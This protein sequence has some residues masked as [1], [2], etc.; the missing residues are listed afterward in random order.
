MP[1]FL[2]PHG[3]YNPWNSPGQNTGVG[4][5]SLLQGSSQPR[6]QTQVSRIAGRFFTS[7]A[8]REALCLFG[9][10]KYLLFSR[11]SLYIFKVFFNVDCFLK[12]F[13]NLLQYCFCCMFWFFWPWGMWDLSYLLGFKPAPPSLEG[14]VSTTGPPEKSQRHS[15]YFTCLSS[16]ER[17][18]S[19]GILI[20][21]IFRWNYCS[22]HF[23]AIF[24]PSAET[25]VIL[26]FLPY[27]S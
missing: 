26:Y 21:N 11:Y 25:Q 9:Y 4:S 18:W 3:L 15:R 16:L 2:R 12:A 23:K 13:I 1:D 24:S 8:T 14:E 27:A 7:W 6:D 20:P 17:V 22:N 19:L 5:Y 10:W